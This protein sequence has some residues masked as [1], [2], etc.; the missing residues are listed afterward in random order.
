MPTRPFDPESA[1]PQFAEL[2]M[3]ETSWVYPRAPLPSRRAYYR[4][5]RR[6]V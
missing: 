5:N 4:A 1:W 6:D 3:L 2:L